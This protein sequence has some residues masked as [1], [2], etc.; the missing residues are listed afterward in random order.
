MRPGKFYKI[1]NADAEENHSGFQFHDGLNVLTEPYTDAKHIF[2][3]LKDGVYLREIELPIDHLDHSLLGRC[4]KSTS[5]GECWVVEDPSRHWWECNKII[6]GKRY[7]LNSAKN[8]YLEVDKFL[9]EN[10][11]N[12]HVGDENSDECALIKSATNSHLEVVKYLVEKGADIHASDECAL[13]LSAKYGYSEVVRFL[14]ENGADMQAQNRAAFRW[15]IQNGRLETFKY[16]VV[17]G[18]EDQE[19]KNLLINESSE[20]YHYLIGLINQ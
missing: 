2:K 4:S 1:T 17:K 3:F 5:D 15:S 12:I 19:F 14:V 6:Y 16:L 13:I 11:A 7:D 10:G 18:S 8:G 9:V 20:L